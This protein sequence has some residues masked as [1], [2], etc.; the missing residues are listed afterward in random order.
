MTPYGQCGT[1]CVINVYRAAGV[2]MMDL[3]TL[4]NLCCCAN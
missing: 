2:L 1:S 4:L 3:V